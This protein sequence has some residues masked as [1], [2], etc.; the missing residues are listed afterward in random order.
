MTNPIDELINM[1][2]EEK[3]PK[4][5]E[6]S[7]IRDAVEYVLRR[8]DEDKGINDKKWKRIQDGREVD[9]DPISMAAVFLHVGG[10]LTLNGLAINDYD[11]TKEGKEFLSR[12]IDYKT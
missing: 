10:Y 6:L 2:Y 8:Y 11:I 12:I 5:E 9:F 7:V 1:Y 4:S 3:S